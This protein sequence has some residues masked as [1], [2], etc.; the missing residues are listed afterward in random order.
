M[1]ILLANLPWI[2]TEEFYGLRAG[3]RWPHLRNRKEMLEYY[4]FPFFLA[5]ASAVLKEAGY[6]IILKDCIAEGITKKNF[7][8]FSS[9]LKPDIAVFET[10]TPSIEMI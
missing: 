4:P 5:Y 7:I 9:E 10:S 3:S 2:N 6:E 8:N 1:K